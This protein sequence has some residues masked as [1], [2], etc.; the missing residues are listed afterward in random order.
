MLQQYVNP[1]KTER[2]HTRFWGI[3]I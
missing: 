1:D 2:K 3:P